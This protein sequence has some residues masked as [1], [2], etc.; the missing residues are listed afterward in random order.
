MVR[1]SEL[2]FPAD[3]PLIVLLA[4]LQ[5]GGIQPRVARELLGVREASRIADDRPGRRCRNETVAGDGEQQ[6]D[7]WNVSNSL[8][9]VNVE[10]SELL[11]KHA[12]LPHG[13]YFRWA[14]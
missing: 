4:G 9:D 11:R 5:H 10:C 13:T 8:G 7:G 1:R 6:R 14:R 3:A 2:P 12:R